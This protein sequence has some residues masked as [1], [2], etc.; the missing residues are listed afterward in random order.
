MSADVVSSSQYR[1]EATGQRSP[2][3]VSTSTTGGGVTGMA[4][5]AVDDLRNRAAGMYV[6]TYSECGGRKKHNCL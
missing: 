4:T 1:G 5:K 2:T 3:K 6:L